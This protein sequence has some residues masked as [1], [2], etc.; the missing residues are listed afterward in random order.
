LAAETYVLPA[1]TWAERKR[2]ALSTPT[3]PAA[4]EEL[5]LPAAS[6]PGDIVEGVP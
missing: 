1:M 2:Q 6:E 4:A 5:L 3:P